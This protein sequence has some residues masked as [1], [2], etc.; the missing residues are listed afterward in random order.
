MP[1]DKFGASRSTNIDCWSQGLWRPPIFHQ[2]APS[3]PVGG[4]TGRPL[5]KLGW[6]WSG[7]LHYISPN[8]ALIK[9]PIKSKLCYHDLS[10]FFFLLV[11]VKSQFVAVLCIST[12]IHIYIYIYCNYIYIE[13]E[14]SQWNLVE[15]GLLL[16]Q[17]HCC[18][19]N[20][21]STLFNA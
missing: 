5:D 7:D 17:S 16:V 1:R 3:P 18:W 8:R 13:R 10:F 21:E 2:D 20:V 15:S 11:T 12:Y 4:R 14:R 19:F 9:I 6:R